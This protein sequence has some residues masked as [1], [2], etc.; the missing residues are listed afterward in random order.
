MPAVV[1]GAGSDATAVSVDHKTVFFA[2]QKEEFHTAIIKLALNGKEHDVIVRDF[3]MHPV[4]REVR[5]IDFQIVEAGKPIKIRL[6]L[7]LVNAE[8]SQAVKL[9]NSRMAL[10]STSVEV[11][12]DPKHIPSELVLDCEKVVAGDVLHLS[13]IQYP[14]G[15]ESTSLRRGANL[16]V[17]TVT[18][19]GK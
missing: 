1:Y 5:H 12:L 8:K 14:E 13:D 3:Q 6:P 2:L 16:A 15:V 17:A 9:Q 11:L 4:R 18:A 7:H 10:L 19:A